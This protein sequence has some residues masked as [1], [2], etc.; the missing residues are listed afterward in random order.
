MALGDRYEPAH[1]KRIAMSAILDWLTPWWAKAALIA[2]I[3][4]M[5]WWAVHSYN[6]A[7]SKKAVEAA[8]VAPM[9]KIKALD[10]ELK[11]IK[12]ESTKETARRKVELDRKTLEL[13]N[14]LAQNKALNDNLIKLRATDSDFERL[15]NASN[16]NSAPA[17]GGNPRCVQVSSAHQQCERDLRVSI[18]TATKSLELIGEC[19]ASVK[20]LMN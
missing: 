3:L 20:A 16:S 4:G 13:K 15:L 11:T 14:A 7:V 8:L 10:T 9:A 6:V 12:D 18:D 5:C 1:I 17:T 2:A 19:S